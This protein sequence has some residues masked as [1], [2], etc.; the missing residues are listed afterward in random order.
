[1][2]RRL[3]SMLLVLTLILPWAPARAEADAAM[4]SGVAS[5]LAHWSDRL[6][7]LSAS[8]PS[9]DADLLVGTIR[10]TLSIAVSAFLLAPDGDVPSGPLQPRAPEYRPEDGYFHSGTCFLSDFDLYAEA[11]VTCSEA[12][13]LVSLSMYQPDGTLMGIQRVELGLRDEEMM[14]LLVD[15][16]HL[17]GLTGRFAMY[18]RDNDPRILYTRTIG[19]TMD[20]CLDVR[21]WAEGRDCP[22]WQKS[23]LLP[24]AVLYQDD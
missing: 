14:A 11:E 3:I 10:N 22:V 13:L 16:D 5:T 18:P 8:A 19:K 23:L 7:T 12:F 17:R 4:V 15:Y 21:A 24:A 2:K 1:M 6:N 9:E 20:L